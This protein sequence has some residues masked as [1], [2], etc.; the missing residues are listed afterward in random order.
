MTGAFTGFNCGGIPSGFLPYFLI[1]PV[2]IDFMGCGVDISK[3]L[4]TLSSVLSRQEIGVCIYICDQVHRDA[5]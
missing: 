2:S 1:A 4:A 3:A 5:R